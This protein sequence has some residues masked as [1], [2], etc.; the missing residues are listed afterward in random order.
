M[1]S[2]IQYC[3]EQN[4]DLIVWLDGTDS[5]TIENSTNIFIWK[6]KVNN[7]TYKFIQTNP[8]L[9]PKLIPN[10]GV[11]FLGNTPLITTDNYYN[12]NNKYLSLLLITDSVIYDY[13]SVLKSVKNNSQSYPNYSIVFNQ[14]YLNFKYTPNYSYVSVGHRKLDDE[15]QILLLE[16]DLIHN[17]IN[18]RNVINDKLESYFCQHKYSLLN[19]NNYSHTI[20]GDSLIGHIH[21]L[22]IFNGKLTNKQLAK[23]IQLLKVRATIFIAP[24]TNKQIITAYQAKDYLNHLDFQYISEITHLINQQNIASIQTVNYNNLFTFKLVPIWNELTELD[25]NNLDISWDLI[26]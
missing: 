4:L 23:I 12:I 18:V 19:L 8:N 6:N 5:S 15:T 3:T 7:Q 1:T 10:K 24:N 26:E 25:W 11:L 9:H 21:T 16:H 22:L 13:Q 14:Q 20:L 2:F 17:C